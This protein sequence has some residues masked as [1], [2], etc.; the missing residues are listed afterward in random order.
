MDFSLN[1]SKLIKKKYLPLP[2]DKKEMQKIIAAL[3]RYGYSMSQIKS[4]VLEQ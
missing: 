3:M 2:K 4:A 1:C